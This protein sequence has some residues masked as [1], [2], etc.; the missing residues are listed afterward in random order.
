MKTQKQLMLAGEPYMASDPELQADQRAAQAWM[1]RY[2]TSSGD[3]RP[4]LLAEG[5]GA[6]GQNVTIRA[7]FHVD[8][9]YNI[10]VGD[11]LDETSILGPVQNAMQFAKVRELVEDARS[12]G[13][14]REQ[15]R[16]QRFHIG[17]PC[18]RLL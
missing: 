1:D 13:G 16:N 4:A 10:R 2:N 12:K 9:G 11:G 3:E 18:D 14:R 15:G 8:Y 6:V 7:P 5:L 17:S